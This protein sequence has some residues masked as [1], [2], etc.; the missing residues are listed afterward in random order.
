MP[1]AIGTL[2]SLV[3]WII[4]KSAGL[5][6][7]T[8]KVVG[9]ALTGGRINTRVEMVN[10]IK[11][12]YVRRIPC[13]VTDLIPTKEMTISIKIRLLAIEFLCNLGGDRNYNIFRSA[14]KFNFFLF[15][16]L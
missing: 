6:S 8:V 4:E 16:P 3:S 14:L 10:D 15:F 12:R 11:S 9:S 2:A 1:V 7:S 13:F 5:S